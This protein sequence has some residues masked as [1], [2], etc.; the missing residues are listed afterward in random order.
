MAVQNSVRLYLNAI[1]YHFESEYDNISLAKISEIFENDINDDLLDDVV[2]YLENE[3]VEITRDSEEVPSEEELLTEIADDDFE[4]FVEDLESD[5]E[6]SELAAS[7]DSEIKVA[8]FEDIVSVSYSADDPVKMYLRDIGQVDLLTSMQESEYA[9]MYQESL[10]CQDKI[11][12]YKKQGKHLSDEEL[13][14]LNEKIELGEQA[15]TIL[16]ESNLRLVVSIAK[17]YLG[18]GLPFLDLIQEGNMG[19]MKAVNKFDPTK[20]FKFSTYATWWIRQAITRA[21]ADN[22]RT[23][24]IPVHMVETI[25]K[26]VRTTRRLTQEKRREPTAEEI[27]AEMKISVEKVQNIQRIAQEPMSFDATVGEDDDSSLGDFIDDKETLNP[28]EYTQNMIYREEIEKVLQT[29]TPREEKVIRLRYGLDDNRPRTL[30]EVGKEFNV[31]RERIRQ[32]EAKAI[33][34]L[35]HPSRLKRLEQHRVKY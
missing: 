28:L 4:A 26:L 22:A 6:F 15:R 19:L 8:D 30:E 7:V 17:R 23:I 2:E 35:R 9:R 14:E 33:R 1:S 31:T 10:M 27:A 29:L 18:R 32:I 21:I 34:R 20:G 24:R 25:N 13:A 16:I 5:D 3:G 11:D 12:A